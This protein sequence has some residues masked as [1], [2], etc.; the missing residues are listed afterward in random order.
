MY[1]LKQGNN[2][3]QE[4]DY[5][6]AFNIFLSLAENGDVKAQLSVA[7]MY[8]IGEFVEKDINQAIKWYLLAAEQGNPIAQN[9][10][11][12]LLLCYDEKEAIKWLFSAAYKGVSLAQ[13]MLGDIYT[14]QYNKCLSEYRDDLEGINWY[15]KAGQNGFS[16][17]YHR[18]GEIYYQGKSVIK[19]DKQAVSYFILAAEQHYKPSQEILAQ[20]YQKGLLGLSPNEEKYKYWLNKLNKTN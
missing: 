20:A 18:L 19:D 6:K 1:T 5:E 17:G 4:G 15:L 14:G 11:A 7:S 3:Y 8:D 10:L 2:A 16:Y 12:V 13:S 9:N